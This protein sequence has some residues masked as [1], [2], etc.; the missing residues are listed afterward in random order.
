MRKCYEVQQSKY[1]GRGRGN[2]AAKIKAILKQTV[3]IDSGSLYMIQVNV[4]L[5]DTLL[6]FQQSLYI[7]QRNRTECSDSK[8]SLT[9]K[10]CTLLAGELALSV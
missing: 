9:D 6:Q 8:G 2:I 4:S 5:Q 3:R 7:Q 1:A 10:R